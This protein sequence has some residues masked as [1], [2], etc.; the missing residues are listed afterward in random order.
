MRVSLRSWLFNICSCTILYP[1]LEHIY[2]SKT[3]KRKN[4]L[5]CM[6]LPRSST[7]QHTNSRLA[8][9]TAHSC[10]WPGVRTGLMQILGGQ[11]AGMLVHPPSTL[12][13]PEAANI[14]PLS[15]RCTKGVYRNHMDAEDGCGGKSRSLHKQPPHL[16]TWAQSAVSSVGEI[17]LSISVHCPK[18]ASP[19]HRRYHSHHHCH[20][21]SVKKDK[22]MRNICLLLRCP[23]KFLGQK[24]LW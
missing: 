4:F 18:A 21:A 12:E 24:D 3:H 9:N 6:L 19:S 13:L 7:L 16:D 22:K 15:F 11:E 14:C 8:W 1:H 23:W 5:K 2:P 10:C 20:M 17:N